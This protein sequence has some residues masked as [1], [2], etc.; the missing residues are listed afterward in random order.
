MEF[1]ITLL[2]AGVTVLVSLTTFNQPERMA[3]MLMNPYKV[4][5]LKEYHRLV[6]HGFIHADFV[7]LFFNMFIFYQFGEQ[8]ELVF[9]Q[10][11]AFR[12]VLP[13]QPF[14]GVNTGRAM[15]VI[16]YFG[17]ILAG[18]LPSLLKHRNNPNY[19]SLGASGAVSAVLLVFIL[20][21]P[22]AQLALF[23]IIPMPAFVAGILFF[24]YEG[25]MNKRGRTG[26][27]HDAHLYGAVFG[28]VLMTITSPGIWVRFIEQ[29]PLGFNR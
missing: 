24:V 28:L 22:M 13:S 1:S 16:L 2:I 29:L 9:T 27:A 21:F 11:W 15:F 8:V 5:Q 20:M 23:F 10:E 18:A 19:N 6:T 25:Y 7:H 26:I 3:K 12:Q 14:W 4:F 17:A